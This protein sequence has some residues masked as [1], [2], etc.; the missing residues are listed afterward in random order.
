MKLW[1]NYHVAHSVDD[2]LLV[3]KRA[4]GDA[5]IIAG[6]T[7]LLLDIQQG[8][9]K[10]VHT[11]VDVNDIPEMTALEIRG[12]EL[13]IGASVPHR[14]I[15]SSD[16]IQDHCRAL[17]TASGLIGGPQVR[18]TAT[19]GGNVAHALPAADGTIA[20][21]SLDAQAEVAS[22]SGQRRLPLVDLFLGPGESAL[23]PRDEVLTGF[24]VGLSESG[25]ASA[26]NRIMRPQGVAI[27]ILNLAVWLHRT[28]DII[29][30]VRIAVGPSG[31]VPRRMLEAENVLR[32]QPLTDLSIARAHEA[33]L[34]EASFRTCRHRATEEYR[35]RMV[36]VLLDNTLREAFDRSTR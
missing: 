12:G 10:P 22:R 28:D 35:R 23:K 26:F 33:V 20:L 34:G 31:P 24:Y 17:A 21:V 13:F 5:Q 11:F 27:A 8:R 1:E 9:H 18:N 29:K 4:P 2:A 30:D 15:T 6:G 14:E 32:G 25:Q 16:V 7:D 3:L 19:I 36:G